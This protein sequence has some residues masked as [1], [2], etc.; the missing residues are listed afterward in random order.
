M[1]FPQEV[2]SDLL[3]YCRLSL[4]YHALF[5]F[6]TLPLAG[7]TALASVLPPGESL[8]V[9]TLRYRQ[10]GGR[11]RDRRFTFSATSVL[12]II[13]KANNDNESRQDRTLL[14]PQSHKSL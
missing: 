9:D 12:N 3:I 5:Q 7:Y 13:I 6:P 1:Q 11:T 14:K 8:S 4:F 10:T 2:M